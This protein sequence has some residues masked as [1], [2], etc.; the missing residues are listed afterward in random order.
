MANLFIGENQRWVNELTLEVIAVDADNETPSIKF[1]TD[2]ENTLSITLKEDKIV[3]MENNWNQNPTSKQSLFPGFIFGETTLEEIISKFETAGYTYP[4][5]DSYETDTEITF[6]NCFEIQNQEDVTLIV[7]TTLKKVKG[8]KV[9]YNDSS[10]LILEAIIL[11]SS[12]YLDGNWGTNRS[13][14]EN[15]K[16]INVN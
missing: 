4:N 2:N 15:Y 12:N 1:L 5:L 9:N 11:S 3:F 7:I 8:K 14:S 6:L 13:Y 16:K 10:K